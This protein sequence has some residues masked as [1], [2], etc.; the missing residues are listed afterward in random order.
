MHKG[1]DRIM[2]ENENGQA[3]ITPI[4][5]FFNGFMLRLI[6]GLSGIGIMAILRPRLIAE[7]YPAILLGCLTYLFVCTL[8]GIYDNSTKQFRQIPGLEKTRLIDIAVFI[9]V[10]LFFFFLCK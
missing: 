10:F 6:Y 7:E 8:G 5:F 1:V 3:E 4:R 9:L 2:P